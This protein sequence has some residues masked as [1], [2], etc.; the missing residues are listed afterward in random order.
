[1]VPVGPGEHPTQGIISVPKLLMTEAGPVERDLV[2][3]YPGRGNTERLLD[4]PAEVQYE[5]AAELARD[6]WSDFPSDPEPFHIVSRRIGLPIPSSGRFRLM[7][8]FLD[9]QRGPVAFAG[10]YLASPTAEGALRS[11]GRAAAQ[12][13]EAATDR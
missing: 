13:A 8:D 6:L 4:A 5:S 12:L 3:V 7:R 1:M 11:G 2:F 9:E 10:D